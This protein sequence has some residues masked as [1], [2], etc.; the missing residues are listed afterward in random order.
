MR[1]A[2]LCLLLFAVLALPSCAT[3][4]AVR[5][6]Y[7]MDSIY[8]KPTRLAED[9]GVRS[10]VGLPLIVGSVAADAFTWPFQL[11]FGVWPMWGRASQHMK[12]S[13]SL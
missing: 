7:G 4:H 6:T 12:P 2:T 8:D 10:V 5:W 1:K 13:A 3:T 11:I 9:T